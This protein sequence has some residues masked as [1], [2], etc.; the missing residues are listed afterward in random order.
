M[1]PF[2]NI[3]NHNNQEGKYTAGCNQAIMLIT[4]G[5]PYYYEEVFQKYKTPMHPVRVFT[6]LIGREVTD[7]REVRWMACTNQG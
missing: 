7:F 3:Q 1:I 2:E 6:Y 5:S 4:D